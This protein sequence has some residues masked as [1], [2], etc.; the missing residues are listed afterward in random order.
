MPSYLGGCQSGC[1]WQFPSITT[2]T[3]RWQILA[4][5]RF[6]KQTSGT[7][8]THPE[9][10]V[11]AIS[12]SSFGIYARHIV[13]YK[14]MVVFS[15]QLRCMHQSLFSTSSYKYARKFEWTKL[16]L[17]PWTCAIKILDVSFR[18]SKF[19]QKFICSFFL[20]ICQSSSFYLDNFM[21]TQEMVKR[22]ISGCSRFKIT[23]FISF[24]WCK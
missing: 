1:F 5:E 2:S 22:F 24:S 8:L 15:K 20:N 9:K 21:E 7:E 6:V 12:W 11:E 16:L 17:S 23:V 3:D 10:V 4:S 18:S 13:R 14:T 19:T